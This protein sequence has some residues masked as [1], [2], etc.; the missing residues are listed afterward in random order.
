M[1]PRPP[2]W[3]LSCGNDVANGSHKPNCQFNAPNRRISRKIEKSKK[4]KGPKK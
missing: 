1:M 4:P 3:C 2:V